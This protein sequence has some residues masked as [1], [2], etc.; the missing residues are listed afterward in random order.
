MKIFGIGL[1]RT[2]TKSL[3]EAL[4]I[5]GFKTAHYPCDRKTYIE[6]TTGNYTL[7]ILKKFDGIT[8]ITAVPFYPQLDLG[9][10]LDTQI[11]D[12]SKTFCGFQTH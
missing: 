4:G 7:S 6:L 5:M 11:I 8:D 3:S 1:S 2:G 12:L 10:L 9:S